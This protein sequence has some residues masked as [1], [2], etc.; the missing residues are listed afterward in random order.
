MK[1]VMSATSRG[2][3]TR[4]WYASSEIW[5]RHGTTRRTGAQVELPYMRPY[6]ERASPGRSHSVF[7]SGRQ[8]K[9]SH[10]DMEQCRKKKTP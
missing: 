6:W 3:P 4:T 2:P 10:A 1:P 5:R 7:P 9:D 8:F